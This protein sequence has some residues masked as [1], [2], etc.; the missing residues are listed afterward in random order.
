[1]TKFRVEAYDW[2]WNT[3]SSWRS[4]H[5]IASGKKEADSAIANTVP[6]QQ[7]AQDTS[8]CIDMQNGKSSSRE[9]KHPKKW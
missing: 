2:T 5:G 9:V 4:K 8:S 7:A 1:M 3:K 6:V